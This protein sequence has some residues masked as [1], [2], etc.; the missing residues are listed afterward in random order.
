MSYGKVHQTFWTD[1]KTR[2]FSDDAKLLAVYLVSGPH[3]AAIGAMRLP[4]GYIVSDL[5]WKDTRIEQ[6]LLEMEKAGFIARDRESEWLCVINQVKYDPPT[7]PNQV[8]SL[9]KAA[10]EIGCE[11]IRQVC[12]TAVITHLKALG[13][14]FGSL[15]EGLAKAF[16]TPGPVLT[17]P[18]HVQDHVRVHDRAPGPDPVPEALRAGRAPNATRIPDDWQ[19]S[20]ALKAW[21]LEHE[22]SVDANRETLKFLDYWRASSGA[23][24]RKSDWD[25]T[26]RGWI[27]RAA[28]GLPKGQINGSNGRHRT[29]Q[30]SLRRSGLA[31]AVEELERGK[32]LPAD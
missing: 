31:A 26:W 6:A 12:T 28:E 23:K 30:T 8:R 10:N 4:V 22:P 9:A 19:P 3:R 15:F 32:P 2:A 27:R 7:N 24:A 16:E 21:A 5:R 13:N 29:D 14:D 18:D 17:C 20:D 25:A 1:P 11:S